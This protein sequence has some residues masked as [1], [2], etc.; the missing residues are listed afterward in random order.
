MSLRDEIFRCR[1]FPGPDKN[2]LERLGEKKNQ[3]NQVQT[4]LLNFFFSFVIKEKY[5]IL[6]IIIIVKFYKGRF[7]KIFLYNLLNQNK[8]TSRTSRCSVT[9]DTHDHSYS[10]DKKVISLFRHIVTL[11]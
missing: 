9:M 10:G 8:P 4:N 6:K 7:V 2:Y 11:E 5:N 1:F 3:Y